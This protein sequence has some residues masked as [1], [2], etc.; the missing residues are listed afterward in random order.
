MK[1]CLGWAVFVVESLAPGFDA[2]CELTILLAVRLLQRRAGISRF[3]VGLDL[4]NAREVQLEYV[5][6]RAS[7]DSGSDE[8]LVSSKDSR[9]IKLAY[10]LPPSAVFKP[11][12]RTFPYHL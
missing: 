7:S 3:P 9:A 4:P 11:D 12:D 2:M 8:K 1:Q 6:V 5:R 10:E